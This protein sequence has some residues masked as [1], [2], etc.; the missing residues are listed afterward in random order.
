M[1]DYLIER[2]VTDDQEKYLRGAYRR[3]LERGLID[4]E[5][6]RKI[7][8]YEFGDGSGDSN[9]DENGELERSAAHRM[10]M[11]AGIIKRYTN[12]REQVI[13]CLGCRCLRESGSELHGF[14]VIKC[15]GIQAGTLYPL[16]REFEAAGIVVSREETI[17]PK[18]I[19][20]P[21]RK[22]YSIA[23]TALGKEF[24]KKLLSP[25]T[26]RLDAQ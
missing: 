2:E 7:L 21:P 23:N 12:S 9:N 6:L 19:G 1:S 18:S 5:T 20:R 14:Q 26:C 13:N 15:S 11:E 24:K 3:L 22:L 4:E 10:L 25:T 8:H 16:L 17:D